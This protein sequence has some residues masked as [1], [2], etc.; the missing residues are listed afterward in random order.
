MAR[1]NY[2]MTDVYYTTAIDLSNNLVTELDEALN[3]VTLYSKILESLFVFMFIMMA[4]LVIIPMQTLMRDYYGL[5]YVIPFGL[6]ESNIQ[7]RTKFSKF[8]G[9][10]K[11]FKIA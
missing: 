7:F 8:T 11:F 10:V 3:F 1:G 5:F 9:K 2:I 6:L 4:I